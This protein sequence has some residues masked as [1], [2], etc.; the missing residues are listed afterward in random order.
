MDFDTNKDFVLES[1]FRKK[2]TAKVATENKKL[3][4]M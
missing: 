1:E 4:F 2:R 3:K